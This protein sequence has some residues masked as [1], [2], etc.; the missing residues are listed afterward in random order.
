MPKDD[1]N[2]TESK[3]S[4]QTP[5]FVST[6]GKSKS[7]GDLTRTPTISYK[8]NEESPRRISRSQHH[9]H[10]SQILRYADSGTIY[11]DVYDVYGFGKA[12][13]SPSKGSLRVKSKSVHSVT[14]NVPEEEEVVPFMNGTAKEDLQANQNGISKY[15]APSEDVV[16]SVVVEKNGNPVIEIIPKEK[17]K[18]CCFTFRNMVFCRLLR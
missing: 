10:R 8:V 2:E 9:L 1:N 7:V 18:Q 11:Q 15:R 13:Q 3:L 12:N 17:E 14:D 6:F 5:N 4:L 16:E